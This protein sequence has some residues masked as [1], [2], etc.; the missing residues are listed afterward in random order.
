MTLEF[1]PLDFKGDFT[2][3]FERIT[4]MFASGVLVP[5]DPYRILIAVGNHAT[6]PMRVHPTA[7]TTLAAGLPVPGGGNTMLFR[8]ADWGTA[9]NESWSYLTQGIGIDIYVMTVSFRPLED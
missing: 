2:R 7:D 5:A 3:T 4:G 9:I 6:D 8:F 1:S